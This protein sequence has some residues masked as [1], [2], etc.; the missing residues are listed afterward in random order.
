M[1]KTMMN[2]NDEIT[3]KFYSMFYKEDKTRIFLLHNRDKILH[4]LSLGTKRE[5][6]EFCKKELGF[7]KSYDSFRKGIN[8]FL[9]QIEKEKNTFPSTSIKLKTSEMK[10]TEQP[11]KALGFGPMPPDFDITTLI[12]D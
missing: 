5:C 7:T 11:K 2:E 6:Y 12:G 1:L 10:K 8:K 9:T 4:L 3:T